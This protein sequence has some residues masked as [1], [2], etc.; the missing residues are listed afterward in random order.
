MIPFVSLLEPLHL[1]FAHDP[2]QQL[3]SPLQRSF[4]LPLSL[5]VRACL[6]PSSQHSLPPLL[7]LAFHCLFLRSLEFLRFL[8]RPQAEHLFIIELPRQQVDANRLGWFRQPH[9]FAFDLAAR[10]L[11]RPANFILQYVVQYHHLLVCS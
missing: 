1:V 9:H 2:L 8:G 10:R 4:R 11:R 5:F 6:V 3:S 7:V